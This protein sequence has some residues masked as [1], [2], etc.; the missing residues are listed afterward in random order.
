MSVPLLT[1]SD[2]TRL[3]ASH[4]PSPQVAAA[5]SVETI[6][7]LLAAWRAGTPVQVLPPALP[8]SPLWGEYGSEAAA[9]PLSPLWGEYGSEAAAHPL[10]PLWGEYGS[11]A[12]GRGVPHTL[13]A[14]S[15]TTGAPRWVVLTRD[16]VAAAVAASQARLGNTAADR[17]LLVLPLHHVGGLS[18]L[19]RTVA[20]GGGVVLHERFDAARVAATLRSGEATIAS[21]VPTMLHRILAAEPGPYPPVKVL[22]GGAAAPPGLVE[23]GLDAGL[24]VLATYGMTEACSQVA[25]VAPGEERAALGTAGRPLDGVVVSVGDDGRIAVA[26]PTVSPGRIVVAGPTVS[27]GYAG[28]PPREGPFV[29]N[30]VGRLDAAGRLVLLG[31]A[32]DVI[33]TGG[34]NVWPQH[35]EEVLRGHP[36]VED[37]AVYG[38]ADPEWGERVTAAFTGDATVPDLAAWAAD[39]LPPPAVPK[40]WRRV[41]AIPRTSLGKLDRDSLR[42]GT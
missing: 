33:V 14:T 41:P 40:D 39:R 13:V 21:L 32:D 25:T 31:R 26:G 23:R 10:S 8:L 16:N 3:A 6:G 15:G 30:D 34:E 19:W 7:N 22:L 20:A 17:W 29:T 2:L 42:N 9:L 5:L 38:V 18:V 11:E 35:V 4:E 37:A 27:P 36:A 28:E 1:A 12:A 24:A